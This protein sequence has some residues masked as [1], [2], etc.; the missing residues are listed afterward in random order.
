MW[1]LACKDQGLEMA[2]LNG[3]AQIDSTPQDERHRT[4][5][6]SAVDRAG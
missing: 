3:G 5:R 6:P 1:K 4:D 2:L